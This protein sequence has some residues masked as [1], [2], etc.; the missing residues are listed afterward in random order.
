MANQLL[1]LQIERPQFSYPAA[2][3][4]AQDLTRND[5]AIEGGRIANERAGMD[6][7]DYAAESGALRDYRE[8]AQGDDPNALDTL[9]GRPELQAKIYKALES[10]KPDQLVKAKMNAIAMLEVDRY[11][12]GR[13]A[14]GSPEEAQ[15]WNE[16]MARLAADGVI[17]K[18]TAAYWQKAGPSDLLRDQARMIGDMVGSFTKSSAKEGDVPENVTTFEKHM[19]DWDKNYAD[20]NFYEGAPPSEGDLNKMKAAR[21]NEERRAR[22]VFGVEGA[23]PVVSPIAG[24]HYSAGEE[25]DDGTLAP[26][27][28]PAASAAGNANQVR[29][30]KPGDVEDGFTFVGGDAGDPK[31]WTK[32]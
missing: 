7:E 32:D 26:E 19:A 13:G 27:V 21:M 6:L 9:K 12:S 2:V 15:A 20:V 22:G 17:D 8:A 1:A 18:E 25:P 29:L 11:V 31:N 30:P 10:M 5:Q 14:P 23:S 3:G 28:A 4:A 24:K 16:G